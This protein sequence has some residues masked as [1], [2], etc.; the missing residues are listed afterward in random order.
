MQYFESLRD[1][2]IGFPVQQTRSL[3]IHLLAPRI[4]VTKGEPPTGSVHRML[5]FCVS[6]NES[7]AMAVPRVHN[8]WD[9]CHPRLTHLTIEF[10][11]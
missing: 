3:Q 7:E 5:L 9:H 10:S 6:R 4:R 1:E 11:L 8:L 2:G